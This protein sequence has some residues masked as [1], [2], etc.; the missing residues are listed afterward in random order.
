MK[1]VDVDGM[2]QCIVSAQQQQVE[3]EARRKEPGQRTHP[4]TE[5]NMDT[6]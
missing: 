2:T 3:H 4:R 6:M 1:L 5:P